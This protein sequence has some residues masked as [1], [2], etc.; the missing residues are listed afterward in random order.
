MHHPIECYNTL[1][2]DEIETLLHFR[3]FEILLLGHEHNKKFRGSDFGNDQKILFTRGRS[4]F[5]KPHEKEAKYLSGYTIIDIE[6]TSKSIKCNYKIYDKD[7]SKFSDDPV[8]GEAVKVYHYG[9][10]Q[11]VIEKVEKKGKDFFMGFSKDEF[12]NN[13]NN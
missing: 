4:A 11:E 8:G 13:Q 3:K 2:G 9:V 5:D 1:E 10:S 7:S 12:T 6:F